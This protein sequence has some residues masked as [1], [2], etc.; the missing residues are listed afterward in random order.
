M[1]INYY[2][3]KRDAKWKNSRTCDVCIVNVHRASMQK[4]LRSKEHL[5]NEKQNELILPECLIEEGQ[6]PIKKP[7]KKYITLKH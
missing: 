5:E 2:Y 7:L 4:F 1:S 6:A 3:K